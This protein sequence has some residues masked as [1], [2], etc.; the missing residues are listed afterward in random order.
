MQRQ[1]ILQEI[2]L[3]VKLFSFIFPKKVGFSLN[4]L[5]SFSFRNNQILRC[6]QKVI[7]IF[8]SFFHRL[9]EL[10]FLSKFGETGVLPQ[11]NNYFR[12]I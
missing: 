9:C 6:I 12:E 3:P 4:T 11:T 10:F 1:G 7:H 2:M 5:Y 8:H